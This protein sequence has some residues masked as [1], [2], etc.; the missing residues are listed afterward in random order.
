MVKKERKLSVVPLALALAAVCGL[1]AFRAAWG[2]PVNAAPSRE[3]ASGGPPD[4]TFFQPVTVEELREQVASQ[5]KGLT[6]VKADGT[7]RKSGGIITGDVLEFLDGSGRIVETYAAV[8][9]GGSSSSAPEEPASSAPAES[10][11]TPQNPVSSQ[12][13][14]GPSEEPVSSQPAGSGVASQ[15]VSSGG[16]DGDGAGYYLFSHPVT[17]EELTAEISPQP[18]G[19]RLRVTAPSGENRA[20]GRVCTGDAVETLDEG[21][22]VQSR[23]TAVIPGDL[24]GDG[25]VTD[26]GLALMRDCLLNRESLSGLESR[27]AD[28]DRNGLVDTSDLLLMEKNVPKD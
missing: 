25:A 23:V 12:D 21:G 17:V 24:T 22:A 4:F 28:M 11:G 14:D 10:D 19:L 13:P 16:L 8:V 9:M 15:P 1:F 2:A 20:S 5:G 7:E 18:H 6:V 26:A 27:A 3:T